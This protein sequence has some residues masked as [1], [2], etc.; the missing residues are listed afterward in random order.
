MWCACCGCD[1]ARC[2]FS[3]RQ[4]K[5]PA[6]SR[7][8]STCSCA[9]AAATSGGAADG[10]AVGTAHPPARNERPVDGSA[11]NSTTPAPAEDAA[12]A[13]HPTPTLSP[14]PPRAPLKVCSWAACGKPLSADAAQNKRCARC[15]DELYCDRACQK[16]HWRAGGHRQNCEEPPCCAICLDGGEEP[17]PIQRGCGCRGDASLAHVTC[18]AKMNAHKGDAHDR[19]WHRCP[20][21]GQDYTGPMQLGLARALRHQVRHRRPNDGERLNADHTLG[22]AL[23]EAGACAEAEKVQKRVLVASTRIQGKEHPDTLKAANDL[24]NTYNNQGRLAEAEEL[25]VWILAAS[26]RVC[27]KEHADTLAAG[28]NLAITFQ[29]Q[30]RLDEAAELQAWVLA[31]RKRLKG[32]EHRDTIGAATNLAITYHRQGKLAEA[33]EL[34]VGVLSASERVLGKNH[35]VSRGAVSNLAVLR[36]A[37]DKVAE[38]VG[39][40]DSLTAMCMEQGRHAEAAALLTRLLQVCTQALGEEHPKTLSLAANLAA[41]HAAMLTNSTQGSPPAFV[42][43]ETRGATSSPESTHA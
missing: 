24:G 38:A 39:T 34:Q 22:R 2:G 30:G 29:D 6:A 23:R 8:C 21:C 33:R 19:G 4:Q 3:G 32:R 26:K 28:T 9:A 12:A 36:Q 20:T 16:K 31:A 43:H 18:V 37:Q 13:A 10:A 35:P 41:T 17:L 40:A 15:K 25:Q 11:S 5:K 27:G 14:Q 7:K 42:G 1:V